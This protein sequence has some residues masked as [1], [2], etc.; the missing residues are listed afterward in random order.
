MD[1]SM[2]TFYQRALVELEKVGKELKILR[3]MTSQKHMH[4]TE[5][6]LRL[7]CEEG[8]IVREETVCESCG[9]KVGIYPFTYEYQTKNIYH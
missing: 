3:G 7:K 6:L 2:F 4:T 5:E 1:E 8:V 9:K